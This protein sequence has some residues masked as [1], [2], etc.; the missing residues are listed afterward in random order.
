MAS[1]IKYNILFLLVVL[2]TLATTASC[3]KE[4]FF[5]KGNLAFSVDTVV[6]D[7]VFTTIGSTTQN[8]RFYNTDNKKLLIEEIQLMGGENSPFRINIDGISGIYHKD[9]EMLAKDS[10]YGF[11]E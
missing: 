4:K 10:L 8:F 5:S 1:F 9:I 7:T 6:F 2:F 11:V 3:K